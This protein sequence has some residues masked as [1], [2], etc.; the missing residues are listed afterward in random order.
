MLMEIK[1]MDLESS[2]ECILVPGVG[3]NKEGVRRSN[4][5]V[6]LLTRELWW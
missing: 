1:L 4:A 6:S 5:T 2:V 3:L